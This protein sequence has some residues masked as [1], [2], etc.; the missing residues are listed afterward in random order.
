SLS[1]G[2]GEGGRVLLHCFA[3]CPYEAIC[4]AL[5]IERANGGGFA[6]RI[7]ATYDYLDEDGTLLHQ[8]VRY[9]PKG[10]GLRRPDGAGG[11]VWELEGVRRVP[12]RLPELLAADTSAVVYL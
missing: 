2:Q 1:V 6:R 8:K 10:F 4:A 9:E 5:G 12:Y 7:V 3:G 11:W